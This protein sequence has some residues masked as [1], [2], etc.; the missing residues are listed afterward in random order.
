MT[1]T[2]ITRDVPDA[3]WLA[4]NEALEEYMD[5]IDSHGDDA[6]HMDQAEHAIRLLSELEKEI[7]GQR[8]HAEKTIQAARMWLKECEEKHLKD[9]EWLDRRLKNFLVQ[10]GKK[11]MNLINGIIKYRNGREVVVVDDETGFIKW[12]KEAG[13]ESTLLRHTTSVEVNKGPVMAYCK[14]TQSEPIPPGISIKRNDSTLKV[15]ISENLVPSIS[16]KS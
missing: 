3:E 8:E 9:R 11:T 16:I 13:R 2:D 5:R 12:A 1:D 15:E 4:E 10:Q 14:S 7:E 6:I